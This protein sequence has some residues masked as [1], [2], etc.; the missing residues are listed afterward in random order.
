MITRIIESCESQ[1]S[2][3]RMIMRIIESC[4]SQ[5]TYLCRVIV[6]AEEMV[7]EEGVADVSADLVD[8]EVEAAQNN[9]AE[10][11]EE[12]A[13]A[14]EFEG[15]GTQ[16]SEGL[17]EEVAD[18]TDE[19][20]EE[21]VAVEEEESTDLEEIDTNKEESAAAKDEANE[22]FNPVP[23]DPREEWRDLQPI[24]PEEEKRCVDIISLAH[25]C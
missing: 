13:K 10:M 4:E 15:D 21:E 20:K 16:A 19:E 14:K 25:I 24:T 7:L 2:I 11:E 9:L 8:A 18:E 1:N 5:N 12:V 23:E 3:V 17:E 6:R 22:S